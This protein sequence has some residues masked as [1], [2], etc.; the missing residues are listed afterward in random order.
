MTTGID[1]YRALDRLQPGDCLSPRLGARV[2]QEREAVSAQLLRPGLDCIGVLDFELDTCLR[3][4]AVARPLLAPEAGLS[5]LA[6]RPHGEVLTSAN[7]LAVEVVA[8]LA[9]LKRQA[10]R[11]HVE[12][13]TLGGIG[14]DDGDAGDELDVHDDL[15][16]ERYAHGLVTRRPD[17]L[18][19]TPGTLAGDRDSRARRDRRW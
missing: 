8:A 3:D 6:Q 9:R 12:L 2:V 13:A 10:Q 14:G 5:G 17:R 7:V 15:L 19:G 18:D 16:A 1:P 4:G 11:T